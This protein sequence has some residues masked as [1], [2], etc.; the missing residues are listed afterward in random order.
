[1]TMTRLRPRRSDNAPPHVDSDALTTCSPAQSS[2]TYV[3]LP[4]T[5]D[6]RSSRNA[7]AE[8]PRLNNEQDGEKREQVPGRAAAFSDERRESL[9]CLRPVSG[10]ERTVI[11]GSGTRNSSATAIAPGISVSANTRRY[12]PGAKNRIA[13]AIERAENGAGVIH[14][15]METEDAPAG[16]RGRKARE[17]RVPR[18]AA[19]ALP[20]AVER[21]N[22][23]HLRPAC[24]EARS[25]AARSRTTRNRAITIDLRRVQRSEAQPEAILSRLLTASATPSMIP[26]DKAPAPST[27]DEIYRQ[28]RVDHLGGRIGEQTRPA[29][30]PHGPG[31]PRHR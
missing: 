15:A 25:A 24:R 9:R 11:D 28:Q 14:G 22:Q 13:V 8:L 29:E 19:N 4:S 3:A 18:C 12:S 21:P 17:H 23:Q 5:S 2:G 16:R 26:S 30:Q 27:R 10:S 7:S 1:M 6:R 20:R 31:N